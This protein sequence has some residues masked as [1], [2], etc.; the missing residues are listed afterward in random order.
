MP[1]A[2][3]LRDGMTWLIEQAAIGPLAFRDLTRGLAWLMEWPLWLAGSLLVTG[4]ETGVGLGGGRLDRTDLL[5]GAHQPARPGS[6]GASAAG[7]WPPWS[8]SPSPISSSSASGR[9]PW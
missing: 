8:C 5:G 9:V 2:Q 1:F 4:V 3:W 6:P 7:A